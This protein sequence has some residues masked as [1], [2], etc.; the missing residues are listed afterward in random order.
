MQSDIFF[1]LNKAFSTWNL[2]KLRSFYPIIKELPILDRFLNCDK[3][4]TALAKADDLEMERISR[5][6][7]KWFAVIGM[8]ECSLSVF[9]RAFLLIAI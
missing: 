5:M 8:S 9:L 6:F 7:D 4:D 2:R 1:G 3:K